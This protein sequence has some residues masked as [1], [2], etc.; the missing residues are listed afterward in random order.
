DGSTSLSMSTIIFL[1]G[2]TMGDACGSAGR[3][4]KTEFESQGYE[5]LEVNFTRPD[6]LVFLDRILKSKEIEFAYSFVG[7]CNALTGA[8]GDG[9]EVNLWS[10]LSIPFVSLYGDSPAYFFS[11]HVV[12]SPGFVS[13]Y[14]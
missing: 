12:P 5:F 3:S 14:A 13:L 8:T 7:F 9:K 11:R 1:T 10:T 4:L 6:P 2:Q